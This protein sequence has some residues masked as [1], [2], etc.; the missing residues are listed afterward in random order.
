[1]SKISYHLKLV[2]ISGKKEVDVSVE[3]TIEE[4]EKMKN[5]GLLEP[6]I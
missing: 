3:G 4:I 6:S 5:L 1:M 2:S